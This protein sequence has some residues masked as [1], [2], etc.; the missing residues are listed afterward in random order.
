MIAPVV[1]RMPLK[2]SVFKKL[3]ESL[4]ASKTIIF[5]EEKVNKQKLK[6]KIVFIPLSEK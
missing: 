2:S 6:K 3:L 1:E 5:A 4:E